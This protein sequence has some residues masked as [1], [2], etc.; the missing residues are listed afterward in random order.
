[1]APP[2]SSPPTILYAST[3]TTLS[4]TVA[5]TVAATVAVTLAVYWTQCE[6]LP[7]SI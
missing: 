6:V 7:V 1:M 4:V 3:G 5:A 2:C